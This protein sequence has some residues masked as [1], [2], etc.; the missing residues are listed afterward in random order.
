MIFFFVLLRCRVYQL[1]KS[2]SKLKMITYF[3][4][5]KGLLNLA[6]SWERGESERGEA[7][8]GMEVAAAKPQLRMEG[9]MWLNGVF[10]SWDKRS[11]RSPWESQVEE[12]GSWELSVPLAAPMNKTMF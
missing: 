6:Q 7:L 9:E 8:T 12:S 10:K 5:C 11:G 2:S 1:R 3:L 4:I